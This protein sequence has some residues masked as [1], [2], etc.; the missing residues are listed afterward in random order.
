[1]KK[2]ITV[3]SL[4]AIFIAASS[5]SAQ[6]PQAPTKKVNTKTEKRCLDAKNGEVCKNKKCDVCKNKK[7]ETSKDK[8]AEPV[9]K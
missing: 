6:T 8:K 3:L 7:N 5:L 9:K 2:R 1:M 4:I